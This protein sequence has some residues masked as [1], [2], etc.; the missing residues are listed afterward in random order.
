MHVGEE[1]PLLAP[2][3][4]V[5]LGLEHMAAKHPD[6]SPDGCRCMEGPGIWQAAGDLGLE[7]VFALDAEDMEVVDS[8]RI[9][10]C[11]AIG[12]SLDHAPE[13]DV[14]LCAPHGSSVDCGGRV[15]ETGGD[16]MGHLAAWQ[17]PHAV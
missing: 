10:P 5:S 4:G 11:R 3:V 9:A 13:D 8:L 15:S 12:R 16:N 2:R 14:E 7:D 17:P 6:L 1:G